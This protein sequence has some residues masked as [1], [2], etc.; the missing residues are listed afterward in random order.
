MVCFARG[1][2]VHGCGLEEVLFRERPSASVSTRWT[3]DACQVI[4][5]NTDASL[6][7]TM[8]SPPDKEDLMVD[9]PGKPYPQYSIGL[10]VHVSSEPSL[11]ADVGGQPESRCR[12][13]AGPC[14][15]PVLLRIPRACAL[16]S[17]TGGGAPAYP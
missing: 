8:N 4:I 9:V 14:T 13:G 7:F 5:V 6:P 1:H 12:C 10:R 3:T 2:A 15:I 16:A 17:A 11:G